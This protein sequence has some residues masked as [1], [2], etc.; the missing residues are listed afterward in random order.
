MTEEVAYL[1]QS[2]PTI[3]I[4]QIEDC[5]EAGTSYSITSPMNS[6]IRQSLFFILTLTTVYGKKAEYSSS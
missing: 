5:Q 6:L 3:C 1:V 4:V 2:D